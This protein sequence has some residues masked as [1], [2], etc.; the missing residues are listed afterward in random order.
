M[1]LLHYISISLT[2]I[3]MIIIFIFS[4][5]TGEASS[6]TSGGIVD[7]IIDIFITDYDSYNADTQQKITDTITLIIRKGA[8]L[9]EYAILGFLW[10]FTYASST[11]FSCD[12]KK[13]KYK[14]IALSCICS[15]LYAISDELHQGFVA[16]RSPAALDVLIDTIGGL[17]G[18]FIAYLTISSKKLSCITKNAKSHIK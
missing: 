10:L 5:Q 18:A 12:I 9:T 8:H 14:L 7:T 11:H 13:N 17:I 15:C 2:I 16:D 6:N 3:W 1:K 4:S